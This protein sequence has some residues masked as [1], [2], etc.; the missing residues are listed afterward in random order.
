MQPEE[1]PGAAWN[2]PGRGNLRPEPFR[3]LT[4][5]GKSENVMK[6]QVHGERMRNRHLLVAAAAAVAILSLGMLYRSQR[7]VP[8]TPEGAVRGA[9]GALRE[10]EANP[11]EIE[12]V[13]RRGET[14]SDIFQRHGL[15][16]IQLH[17]LKE[18]AAGVFRL[19]RITP[20]RPY[21]I[22]LDSDNNV[23]TLS[24]QIDDAATLD[25][26]QEAPGFRAEKVAIDYDVREA[27]LAGAIEN[28]LVSALGEDGSSV[29]LALDLS[30]IFSWD[31][32]FNTDI[33]KGDT[34]RV[35]VEEL[36]LNGEFRRY[37]NVL[38][39]E[40]VNDGSVHRAYR[41]EIDGRIG[42]FDDDGNSL[43][44]AFLKAP[45]SYRRI[46]SGFSR[47][48]LHP[49]LKVYRPH[50]GVDYAAARGTPVSALGDGTVKF[51]GWKGAN[52]RLI[53]LR[54]PMGYTTY[55][56]HLSRIAKGIRPGARVAQGDVIGAVGS[57]GRTTGPHL[58]FQINRHGRILNP[59]SVKLPRG[60]GIPKNRME[61]FRRYQ[62]GMKETLA[63][64]PVPSPESADARK[65]TAVASSS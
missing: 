25:I 64:I 31:I 37:G 53:I 26:T 15:D 45:L 19:R 55:Y 32:D 3:G 58:H 4:G 17:L 16:R 7:N 18:A 41:F 9:K 51:A 56:G 20:G 54:H 43:R 21:K 59:L 5:P 10:Q 22:T 27:G 44:R 49:V 23:L 14:M 60:Q 38:S 52:G 29:A 12:G 34:Y 65:E 28:N 1:R 6:I 39:A 48:R 57:T 46:S 61:D 11:Q 13:V 33:R 8:A 2:R 36:W 24:Y 42:Y 50:H 63:S 35:V 62:T 40:F 30:D 47:S